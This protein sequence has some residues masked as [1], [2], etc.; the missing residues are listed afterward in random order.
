MI[1]KKVLM[2]GAQF[3]SN[4]AH[5][6][7]YYNAEA[8]DTKKATFEHDIIRLAFEQAGMD[9]I[10][11]EPPSG[12]QD[13]VY[14][15]NWALVHGNRAIMSRLPDARK[16]EEPYSEQVLRILGFETITVPED[17][18]FSGQGDSLPCGKYLLAGSG[19]RSDP[20][21]QKFAADALGLK[22]IQL[23]TIPELD[24]NGQPMINPISGWAD[25]FFYDID[26]AISVLRED[27]IAYCP[28]AFDKHSQKKIESLPMEKIK[29]GYD[30]AT[31][32]LACNLVSTG[33]VVI[34]SSR[35]PQLRAEVEKRGLKVIT[36]EITE[37]AK[38]GGYIRCVSLTLD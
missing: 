19:Y 13:G 27:L 6:N 14:T 7:P 10:Q 8:I 38:G 12:S 20:R 25:S 34:M 5:I 1:N 22:L 26:L 32:G 28:D 15:A 35:A 23:H 18:H 16:A 2:S 11:V 33:N 17:W 30:E 9:V 31:N 24:T 4:D 3:F 37:L 21:A 29:V 36:P